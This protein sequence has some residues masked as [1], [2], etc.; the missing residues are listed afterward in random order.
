MCVRSVQKA[1]WPGQ[2]GVAPRPGQAGEPRS[3]QPSW[4]RRSALRQ[5]AAA[6]EAELDKQTG[7]TADQ[8]AQSRKA[9]QD[10]RVQYDAQET[11][12]L[13]MIAPDA[14]ETFKQRALRLDSLRMVTVGLRVKVAS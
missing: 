11:T 2:Y 10:M 1:L 6:S 8:I 9:I 4:T 7:L 13:Q 5:Q 14:V 12:A 3:V